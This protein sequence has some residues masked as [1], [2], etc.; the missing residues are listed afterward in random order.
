MSQKQ[1]WLWEAYLAI[2]LF[3]AAERTYHLFNPGSPDFL[4][5]SVLK[6]FGADFYFTYAAHVVYVVLNIIHC[7]PLFLYIYRIDFLSPKIWK[8]L[9]ILRCIFEFTG[10]SYEIKELTSFYHSNPLI[11]LLILLFTIGPYIPSYFACFRYAFL[12]REKWQ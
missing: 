7:V 4:Y 10:R 3:F 1:K 2:I 12:S 8:F 6:S 9:F 11:F 5:Y